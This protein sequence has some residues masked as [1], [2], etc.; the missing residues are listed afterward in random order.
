MKA[1]RHD[2]KIMMGDFNAKVGKEPGL[3]PSVGKYSLHKKTNH[4][5]WRMTD[6]AIVRNMA[7]SSTLFQ[8]K[9]IHKKH[10]DHQ[11]NLHQIKLTKW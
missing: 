6:F 8:H 3:T 4:N 5:G 11:M 10:A 7:I 9:R 2:I 1:P